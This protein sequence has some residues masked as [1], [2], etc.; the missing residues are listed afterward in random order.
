MAKSLSD[1]VG[2]SLLESVQEKNRTVSIL[3]F[4][5]CFLH[6][7]NLHREAYQDL[8]NRCY[9]LGFEAG[10]K[11]ERGTVNACMQAINGGSDNA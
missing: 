9:Q 3:L 7:R 4:E 5:C 2:D 10:R 6:R 11:R 1:I 8:L